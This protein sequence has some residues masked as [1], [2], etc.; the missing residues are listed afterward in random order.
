[1]PGVPEKSRFGKFFNA[2]IH[3]YFGSSA[4]TLVS[5]RSRRGG[6]GQKTPP[7]GKAECAATDEAITA[8]SCVLGG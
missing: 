6:D 5:Q 2:A 1:L 7:A 4:R 8:L 3:V